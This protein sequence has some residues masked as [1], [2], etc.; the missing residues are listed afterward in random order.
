MV[1]QVPRLLLFWNAASGLARE[2][3]YLKEIFFKWNRSASIPSHSISPV[4]VAS[5]FVDGKGPGRCSLPV[6]PEENQSILVTLCPKA[7]SI[8]ADL[9]R[10]GLLLIN[11][12]YH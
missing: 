8:F 6:C 9:N 10:F 2:R 12:F 4:S 5:S 11:W 7:V 3:D 1:T